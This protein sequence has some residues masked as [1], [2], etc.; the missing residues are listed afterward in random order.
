MKPQPAR[1]PLMALGMLALLAALWAGLVRLGWHLPPLRPSLPIAHGPLMVS[2]F[3]GT[4]IA[5]ERAVALR[6]RWT[7]IAPALT[8]LGALLLIAGLSAT[9][10]PLL[11]TLG[12]LGLV[13]VFGVIVRRQTALFTVTMGLGA[14]AWLVGNALWLAGWSIPQV[15]LWW[16]GFLVLTIVGERLELS[17]LLN[18]PQSVR[19]VFLGATGLFGAGLIV[20]LFNLGAGTRLAG[21][22]M[23]ALALWLGRYDIARRT[24]RKA[25]LTR[26]IAVCL[27]A[28][29]V[30]LGVS[31]VLALL[32]GGVMAGPRYDATLHALFLGFVFSMI[33]GHAPVIFPG[34]MGVTIPFRP[35]FYGHLA[36]LHA[37]LLLRVVGD[38]AGWLPGR[39]W[40]GLLNVVALLLFLANTARVTR[41][42]RV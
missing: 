9:A 19:M 2:G 32:Q 14:L 23:V 30:W 35:G 34:V 24:V 36:L 22:G 26:F 16:A 25:G 1:L 13:A 41:G 38:V 28:G 37:S 12:S 18:L 31:G 17:R 10:G 4:V 7:Y 40:G 29:Y 42:V 5:L 21:L 39:Q 20:A 11:L 27:L 15:V 3:L 6:L 33:F 8:G